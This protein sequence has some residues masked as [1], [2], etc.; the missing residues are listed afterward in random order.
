MVEINCSG[1]GK[2]ATNTLHTFFKFYP[3]LANGLFPEFFLRN[4]SRFV[5][6]VVFTRVFTMLLLSYFGI[7]V[8][9]TALSKCSFASIN[10]A[11]MPRE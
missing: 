5:G 2:P 9:H 7:F 8:R 4:Y 11:Y 3:F 1:M 10:Y 6:F